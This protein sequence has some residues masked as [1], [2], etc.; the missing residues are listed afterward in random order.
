MQSIEPRIAKRRRESYHSRVTHR[1]I[2]VVE[3]LIVYDLINC[4][5]LAIVGGKSTLLGRLLVRFR[6]LQ[7]FRCLDDDRM[8][9]TGLSSWEETRLTRNPTSFVSLYAGSSV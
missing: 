8:D 7:T 5:T 2:A 1:Y 9:L 6:E 3:A 4:S